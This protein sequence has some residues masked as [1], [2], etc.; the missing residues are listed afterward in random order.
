MKKTKNYS[1]KRYSIL[2]FVEGVNCDDNEYF[3]KNGVSKNCYNIK[4]SKGNLTKGRGIEELS[5]PQ[6]QTSTSFNRKLNYSSEYRLTKLWRYKYYS[7]VNSRYDYILIGYGTDKKLHYVNLFAYSQSV[8]DIGGFTFNEEPTALNFRINGKDVIGF[9][10]P[11][12]S[13]LVWYCDEAP[14]QVTT[15]PKFDSICLHNERLFAIDSE[16]NYLVRYS[17]NLNPLDWTSNITT[18]SGGTIELNDYKGLL[19]NLVSFLD[20]VYVFR[21]FGISKIS[22][23]ASNSVYTAVNIY[24]S[25]AKIYCKTAC[26]CGDQIYF[27]AE[28]GLFKFDGFN[29]IKVEIK[30]SKLFNNISQENA[31]TCFFN[32]KLYIACALEFED[33]E[34]VGQEVESGRVNNALIEYDIVS[35]EYNILRGIDITSMLAV[36]DLNLSKLLICL[37]NSYGYKCWE[38]CETGTLNGSILLKKWE[39]GKIHF[40]KFDSD[41]VLKEVNLIC[42]YDCLLKIETDYGLNIYEIKGKEDLQRIRLNCIGKIFSFV[43]ESNNKNF[44][45]SSP[46]FVFNVEKEN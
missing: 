42:K 35:K 45:I 30:L 19:R 4:V 24:N 6:L 10:S 8:Y 16:K 23:Y 37:N 9:C 12:D 7:E 38:L 46:Q 33:D 28:D 31:I 36:K 34:S 25:S 29:V 21:D 40:D 3:L 11:S 17:S 20:N 39:S 1:K 22:S 43:F 14:Y 2:N 41:K 5:L 26:I 32:G 27:L 15:V 18:T 13:L 44:F